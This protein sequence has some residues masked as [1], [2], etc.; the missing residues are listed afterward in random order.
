MTRFVIDAPTLVQLVT[1]GPR[2][3]PS[4]QLV[5]PAGIRSRAL[6]LLLQEVRDGKLTEREA[7]ELHER[8]T[9]LKLRLLNDRVSR[10][11]AW[12][13]AMQLDL[14][15]SEAEYLAIAQLQADALVTADSRLAGAAAGV[16][17]LA[18]LSALALP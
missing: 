18:D 10:R 3:D 7:L 5:A 14:A 15:L 13:L 6:Q 1:D 12:R 4:H 8:I 16:V 17:A 9:E 2:I 11:S